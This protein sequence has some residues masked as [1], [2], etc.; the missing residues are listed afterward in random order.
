M[1]RVVFRLIVTAEALIGSALMV[2]LLLGRTEPMVVSNTLTVIGV[3]VLALSIG[4]SIAMSPVQRMGAKKLKEDF[5]T[6]VKDKIVRPGG[7]A[8]RLGP[9]LRGV[10][11]AGIIIGTVLLIEFSVFS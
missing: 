2:L 1:I 11:M 7:F 9:L 4:P 10:L 8:D 5:T 6:Q 3:G